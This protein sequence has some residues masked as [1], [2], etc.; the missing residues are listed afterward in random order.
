MHT[1]IKQSNSNQSTFVRG[2]TIVELLIVIVVIGILAAI[3][4]VGY[5]GIQTRGKMAV[6]NQNAQ[7]LLTAMSLARENK[8][9]TLGEITGSY[10]SVGYC[11][12]ATNNPGAVIPKDLPKSHICWQRY[13]SMLDN[14]S[15]ASYVDLSALK[16]GDPEGN[17][18]VFDENEGEGVDAGLYCRSDGP[19]SYFTNTGG[20]YTGLK[21]IAKHFTADPSCP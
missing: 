1:I 18:Y 15:S 2:F 4:I 13:Y 10:W 12:S 16:S 20:S 17:P 11:T 14:L 8:S 5:N 7:Q 21:P 3:T 9:L 19:I 6:R